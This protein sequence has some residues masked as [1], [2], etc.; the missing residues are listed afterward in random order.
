MSVVWI[1]VFVDNHVNPAFF[2]AVISLVFNNNVRF[3]LV[4]VLDTTDIILLLYSTTVSTV[5]V[6][7]H[8][9]NYNKM[10]LLFK[11]FMYSTL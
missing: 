2:I 5:R 3:S 9:T 6:S 11:Y 8:N 1:Q 7:L 10:S 4:T